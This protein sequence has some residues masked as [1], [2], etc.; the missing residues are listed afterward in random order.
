MGTHELDEV[1]RPSGVD[2]VLVLPAGSPPPNPA[3][4]LGSSAMM[5]VIADLES[6]ADVVLFDSPPTLI[7]AD[8]VVLSSLVD[9]VLIVISFGDTKKAST[10]KAID[11]LNR[12][13]AH[14]LGTVLNRIE[15]P[16]AG[17]YGYGRYYVSPTI[18]SPSMANRVP[19]STGEPR[20]V[21]SAE[22]TDD[23]V[24]PRRGE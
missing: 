6:R 9:G 4:L 11:F 15:G 1:L 21:S 12:A 23:T 10:R 16:N 7:V 2:G 8:S 17:Y 18:D 22:P 13:K 5:R 3:E 24:T 20:A 19:S 14:V